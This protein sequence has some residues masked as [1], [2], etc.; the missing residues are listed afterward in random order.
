MVG[1]PEDSPEKGRSRVIPKGESHFDETAVS[2]AP[3][4][5][6]VE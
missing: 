6:L 4:P 2:A 3:S 5:T 1:R